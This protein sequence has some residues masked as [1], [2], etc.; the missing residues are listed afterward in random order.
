MK[1]LGFTTISLLFAS[2]LI[3]AKSKADDIPVGDLPADVKAVVDAY[4]KLLKESKS[5]TQRS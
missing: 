1:K 3:F 2:A 4:A 5:K